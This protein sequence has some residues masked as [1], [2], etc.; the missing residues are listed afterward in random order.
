[1]F[2][3]EEKLVFAFWKNLRDDLVGRGC[4]TDNLPPDQR[5]LE[6]AT[7]VIIEKAKLQEDARNFL[8]TDDFTQWANISN[9]DADKLR[10]R[11]HAISH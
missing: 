3:P 6:Y 5:R 1:M 4:T 7:R 11:F 10:G 8:S 2:T 9:F